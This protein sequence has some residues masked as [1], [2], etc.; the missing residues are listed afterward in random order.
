M[1]KLIKAVH[2][3]VVGFLLF[4]TIVVAQEKPRVAVLDFEF[5][6]QAS[7]VEASG[8]AEEIRRVFVS[9]KKFTVI[10]RTLTTKVMQ[11]WAIQQSGLTD[12][13]KAIKVGKLYN[14]QVIVTGKLL[15]FP[16]GGWQ[17][18]GVMLDAQTGI[19]KKAET[20]RH[21]GEFFTLLDQKVPGLA[22][23]LAGLKSTI[24]PVSGSTWRDP[25][26]GMEFVW[27]PGGSFEM[28]CHSGNDGECEEDEKPL[29]TVGLDG[30]WMGK[31]EVTQGQWKKIMGNNP[32]Q[33]KK[34]DNY[35]VEQVSWND[36][37]EF[38][39][40]LNARSS[41]TFRL[42][43]EAQWEYA[44]RAGG[45]PIKYAWGNGDPYV[46]G[47]KA[48]NVHDDTSKRVNKFDW[49]HWNGYDDGYAQT[50]PVGSFNENGLG[51]HDMTGNVWEWVQDTYT[52]YG[53]VGT[54]NPKN[55]DSGAGRMDRGGS[56]FNQS[57]YLRCSNR[58][59]AVPSYG[60]RAQGFRLLRI[61]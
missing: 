31:N 51:L 29:R 5:E 56:W 13:E 46:K 7:K 55:E 41:V 22:M 40:K 35:P 25:V 58:I 24:Q 38:I 54:N 19:T 49:Q 34:G 36:V 14:V 45:K 12:K 20:I 44:C 30:F 9:S 52:G 28:G 15:K 50:A 47:Q 6:G 11:E 21:K 37:Q 2:L 57:R 23:M 10:D 60:L 16:G 3:S 27:V 33:F 48:G 8:I 26:T 61:R 4:S 43:S 18:S 32:S 59:S 42:P 53:N 17:I 39:R 1:S